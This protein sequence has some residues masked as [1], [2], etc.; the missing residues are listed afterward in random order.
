MTVSSITPGYYV[1]WLT[2]Y[3]RVLVTHGWGSEEHPGDPLSS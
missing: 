3:L 1:E 2:C